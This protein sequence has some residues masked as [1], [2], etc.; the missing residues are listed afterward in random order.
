MTDTTAHLSI[1]TAD[2]PG[3][4]WAQRMVAERH[5]LRAPVDSR[6]SPVALLLD[7]YYSWGAGAAAGPR[8]VGIL[9]FGRP[10][11]QCCY[12]GALTYGSQADVR[13]GRA[14]FDR[15][16]VL[17]LA[18]VWLAPAVQQ[19]GTLYAPLGEDSATDRGGGV[20]G[21]YDRRG[22]WRS[23]L[24]SWLIGQA[25]ATIG[26][27]Y[28]AQRPP[29][30]P[31]EPY[32]IRAVLSYCDRKRHKGTIYRASRFELARTNDD[33]I[34][35]WYT[36]AVAPLTAEQDSAIQKLSAQSTRGKQLRQRRQAPPEQQTLDFEEV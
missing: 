4:A 33:Q 15:W 31:D 22:V 12:S 10:E 23:T 24:A 6:C 25:L 34:E 26:A 17:N 8:T 32:Q 16:E 29:V 1:S 20:P 9:I 19:G 21:Y 11:A 3:L 2:R 36:Q 13:A 5:Y 7:Y 30:Y 28:L 14:Q 18:R 27:A 35:T